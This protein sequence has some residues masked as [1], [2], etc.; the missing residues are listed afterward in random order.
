MAAHHHH[1]EPGH[2]KAS[3][4]V[5]RPVKFVGD[6]FPVRAERVAGD[7][8]RGRPR[9]NAKRG[10]DAER[11]RGH[12]REP[13]G[14][15]DEGPDDRDDP[16]DKHRDGAV[17]L[18]PGG[19]PVDLVLPH[20]DPPSPAPDRRL[21]GVPADRPGAV[22]ARHAAEHPRRHHAGQRRVRARHRAARERPA[23][24]H[25]DLGRHG[26]AGRFGQHQDEYRK[27]PVLGD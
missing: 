1:E 22:A 10:V 27:V 13:G 14:Q 3:D 15:R 19:S 11:A 23:E 5:G 9:D 6:M 12:V 7:A 17:A 24:H 25:D 8:K 26:N 16:A 2:S 18:E 20:P 4:H 21:A